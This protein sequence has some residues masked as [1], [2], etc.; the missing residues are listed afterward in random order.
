MPKTINLD[1]YEIIPFFYEVALNY[2]FRSV[3]YTAM[4]VKLTTA[5]LSD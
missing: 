4:A 2:L 1:F 5:R 3:N